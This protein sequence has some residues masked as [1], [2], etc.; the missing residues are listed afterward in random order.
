MNSVNLT[1]VIRNSAEAILGQNLVGFANLDMGAS[2]ISILSMGGR[3]P[4]DG[5]KVQISGQSTSHIFVTS[6]PRVN[7]DDSLSSYEVRFTDRPLQAWTIVF[8]CKMLSSEQHKDEEQEESG[9]N[10]S[11]FKPIYPMKKN[12]PLE[13][14]VT[15]SGNEFISLDGEMYYYESYSRISEEP[16]VGK[17]VRIFWNFAKEGTGEKVCYGVYAV[18]P[19][20]SGKNSDGQTEQK[21]NSVHSS[22]PKNPKLYAVKVTGVNEYGIFLDK[23]FYNFSKHTQFPDYDIH[24]GDIVDA[25]VSSTDRTKG[26]R[27]YLQ[28]IKLAEQQPAASNQ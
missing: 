3:L 27:R 22:Q 26:V 12:A 1:G 20:N 7:S 18:E 24:D 2:T 13:G 15:G 9:T 11:E 19:K 10:V 21:G 8:D 4:E 28:S 25:V 14:I 16:V 23:V 17:Q 5:A 6:S